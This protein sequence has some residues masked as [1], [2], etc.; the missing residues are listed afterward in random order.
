MITIIDVF[1]KY[2]FLIPIINKEGPTIAKKLDILF[3]LPPLEKIASKP[4]LLLS[5]NG[6]EFTNDL[7]RKVCKFHNVFQIFSVA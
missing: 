3:S 6:P 5:D 7:V 1:S 2:A 4:K